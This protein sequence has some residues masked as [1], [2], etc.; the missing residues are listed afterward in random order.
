MIE[1]TEAFL[2][3][4]E[5]APAISHGGSEGAPLTAQP[6]GAGLKGVGSFIA[7]LDN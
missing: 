2:E 4:V 3:G 7:I 6:L 5:F 1:A